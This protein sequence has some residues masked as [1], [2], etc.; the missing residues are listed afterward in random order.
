MSRLKNQIKG[1]NTKGLF[2][3]TPNEITSLLEKALNATANGIVITNRE[4]EIIWA[5]PAMQELTGYTVEEMLGKN[6][7]MFNSGRQ[8]R[9]FYKKL[10]DTILDGRVWSGEII[11]RRK[12][13]RVYYEDLTITPIALSG[14]AI[15]HFIAI[16]QDRT[17]TIRQETALRTNEE[18]FQ[19]LIGSIADLV[20]TLDMDERFNG[21]FGQ[22]VWD[23]NILPADLLGKTAR[24]VFGIEASLPHHLAN[25][26]VLLGENV[27]Y[28]WTMNS[29]TGTKTIQIH[30]SPLRDTENRIIGIVG[31]GRDLTEQVETNQRLNEYTQ[32]LEM[33]YEISGTLTGMTDLP[34]IFKVLSE[35]IAA[36]IGAKK[37]VIALSNP[38]TEEIEAQIPAFGVE[39]S[40][41]SEFHY[42]VQFG[43][44][45]W[46]L[47]QQGAFIANSIAEIPEKFQHFAE[48]FGVESV[49]VVPFDTEERLGGILFAANRE[50]GFHE[51]E[52]H[53][54]GLLARHLGA[55][56]ARIQMVS[57]IQKQLNELQV[58]HA[59]AVAGVNA[60]S[61]DELITKV[62]Q[63]VGEAL[64]SQ[65]F[66]VLLVNNESNTLT[67]HP[68]YHRAG[69]GA[70]QLIIPIGPGSVSGMVAL[71]GTPKRLGDVRA[72]SNYLPAN[73]NIQ[74]ELCVPIQV[75]EELIGVLNAESYQLR[76][77]S[78]SDE[79]LLITIA[80]LLGS[81][82]GRLRREISEKHQRILA[83]NLAEKR[84]VLHHASQ[85]LIESG[86][87]IEKVCHA[88]Y[89][90]VKQIMPAD[91]FVI[92]LKN[93]Q[94]KKVDLV[95]GIDRG[96]RV[97]SKSIPLHQGLCGMVMDKKESILVQDL[98]DHPLL[99][100]DAFHFGSADKVRSFV[101]VPIQHNGRIL[102]MLSAQSYTPGVYSTE[103][104]ELLE[105]LAAHA[106]GILENIELFQETQRKARQME[107][108]LETTR[109]LAGIQEL[110]QLL[111]LTLDRAIALLGMERGGMYL[112]DP[113]R[114]DLELVAAKNIGVQPGIRM[115]LGESISGRVA[116]SRKPMVVEDYSSWEGRSPIYEGLHYTSSLDVP[117]IYRG[118]LIG[119]L[120]VTEVYPKT[121]RF[122]KEEIALLQMFA[123]QAAS[124]VRNAQLLNK[125]RR[126]VT[127][128]EA[129]N[130]ISR[131]L[132]IARNLDVI[133]P[134]FLTEVLKV[135]DSSN[136]ALWLYDADLETFQ[137]AA[138]M[139]WID[140]AI[141][142][143]KAFPF[144]LLM[145]GLEKESY[146]II[147]DLRVAAQNPSSVFSSIPEGWNGVLLPIA[148]VKQKMGVLL[149]AYPD[150]RS[151][152]P[153]EI[154]LL[155]A[156]CEIVGNTIHRAQLD[157]QMEKR[158]E[159][160]LSLRTIDN[161][162]NASLDLSLTLDIL[163]DQ[164]INYYH[165]DA[166]DILLY[167][168]HW[169]ALKLA[170]GRGFLNPFPSNQ[171]IPLT[172]GGLSQILSS[173]QIV[174]VQNLADFNLGDNRASLFKK[175]GFR[176][177]VGCPLLAKGQ[178]VGLLELFGR[179]GNSVPPN[180]LDFL[181]TL[182]GQAA[183]AIDNARLFE[184]LQQS[185]AQLYMAYDSTLEGWARTL[186]L[187][188]NETEGHSRRVSDLTLK[189]ARMVGVTDEELVHIRRGTLL[190]DIGK[191][192]IPDE[193]LHKPGPL[194]P[195]EWMIMKQ[196]PIFA[197]QLL[198]P[199]T[200]LEKAIEIPYC[201]HERWDGSGYPRGLQ[202]EQIPLAA[203]IFMVV[204]VYDALRSDRPYRTAWSEE[205]TRN[206]IKQNAGTLF[207]P[208]IVEQFLKLLDK[209]V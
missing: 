175:E 166:A 198:K 148:S 125:T 99:Q 71:N 23:L 62:T 37:V 102:G 134:E 40:E 50:N 90:A 87:D 141:R 193:I 185:N 163:I 94:T 24:E 164:V 111:N 7:R 182:G 93:K 82:I 16:K 190:H 123:T 97:L 176:H 29:P 188:D 68:S 108:L 146:T 199:I 8:D 25:L 136:G 161:A 27:V 117:M 17:Q 26:R 73:P 20:F 3:E 209:G 126:R 122:T 133:L 120:L 31:V 42:P 206:Y 157:R 12:D 140:P 119:V 41:L 151:I 160:L 128:L 178:I 127:E 30:S 153:E 91:A 196:H 76:A 95:Y 58:L 121:H 4:G 105:L 147:E 39:E 5:N 51:H 156:F 180:E 179:A 139:G 44:E 204:D 15:T 203:R 165:I 110:P 130:L 1:N 144:D 46:D 81:G 189:L 194:T 52:A 115:K 107:A 70:K 19:S 54:L 129:I 158:I 69:C 43:T 169:N 101:A 104:V 96:E 88:L 167:E 100:K 103:D 145:S 86:Y 32:E 208:R 11:N 10:W 184:N 113:V 192:G 131:K 197:Y 149:V 171:I 84:T 45:V 60:S 49:L 38:E 61:E 13:G 59:V 36:L 18:R 168:S 72:D 64:Y 48:R 124:A 138:A 207:D 170:A 21:I 85:E 137:L 186:E 74:S 53:L 34:S 173:G 187:R 28:D 152:E 47:S 77:F 191:M 116:V 6:P 22:W 154:N 67:L 57:Y 112:F 150:S 183:I 83:E 159:Q 78:E 205:E 202:G 92:T 174:T 66:G 56:I 155:S 177:Y 75:G 195:E 118:E 98:Q 200:Y 201:H 9:K 55:I 79:R 162:I 2:H 114:K 80:G 65:N 109:D 14:E 135:V 181:E 89:Q 33:L 142:F 63:I 35:R 172:Y 132:R 106:A 143:E